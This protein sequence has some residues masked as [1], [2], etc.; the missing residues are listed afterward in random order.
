MNGDGKMTTPA[1]IIAF[2]RE[3]GMAKWFAGGD[4]F[5]TDCRTRFLD[6]HHASARR[7]CEGWMQSAEGALDP[8]VETALGGEGA[9]QFRGH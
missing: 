5:D 6:A 9:T 2:W 8:F 7:E 3:A 1:D 4:A